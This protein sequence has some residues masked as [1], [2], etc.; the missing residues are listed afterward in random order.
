MQRLA[1]SLLIVASGLITG[2]AGYDMGKSEFSPT[3]SH[4]GTT[5]N[6]PVADQNP[7][8]GGDSSYPSSDDDG[9][10]PSPPAP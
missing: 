9:K 4:D 6:S 8:S 2:C 5:L 10:V 1:L 3:R 7:N